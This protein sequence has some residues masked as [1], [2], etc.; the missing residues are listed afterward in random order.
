M[1][2][3]RQAEWDAWMRRG[4][5]ER[6]AFYAIRDLIALSN[7]VDEHGRVPGP[8]MQIE[9]LKLAGYPDATPLKIRRAIV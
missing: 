6:Y 7:E 4:K 2:I 5:D 8:K 9:L 3:M 1:P